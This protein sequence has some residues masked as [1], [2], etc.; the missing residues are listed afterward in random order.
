MVS[1]QRLALIVALTTTMGLYAQ[2]DPQA[3]PAAESA[4]LPIEQE[5]S[6]AADSLGY[7]PEDQNL[8][9][10]DPFADI[11]QEDV[12]AYIDEIR[13]VD[14]PQASLFDNM[15]YPYSMSSYRLGSDFTGF[16][17]NAV[18]IKRQGF[19]LPDSYYQ[20]WLYLGY[21]SQF[22]SFE[23]EIMALDARPRAYEHQVSLS[24]LEGALGDYDS[25]YAQGSFAKGS[26]FGLEGSSMQFDYRLFNG[27]WVDFDN[28]GNSVRQYLG[29]RYK[30]LTFAVDYASYQK[31]GGSYELN[32]AY[33]HLGNFRIKNRYSQLVAQISHPWLTLSLANFQER[34]SSASFSQSWKTESWHVAAEKELILPLSRLDLRY[35]YRDLTRNYSPPSQGFENE[36]RQQSSLDFQH[37]SFAD[38]SLQAQAFDWDKYKTWLELSKAFGP[39][40][41]G[42]YSRMNHGQHDATLEVT[43]PLDATLIPAVD[44]FCAQENALVTGLNY[45]GLKLKLALGRGEEHQ[46]S[47]QELKPELWVLHL[48]GAFD[49]TFGAWRFKINSGWN[50]HEY[51]PYLVAAPEFTFFSEQRVLL[52]LKH[53]NNLQAGFALQGHS[54]YYLPNAVNPY[55]I[56]ASTMLDAWV[57]VRISKLFDF[58][59]TVKNLLSTSIYGLYPIPQSLHANLRWF[60]IN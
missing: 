24:R 23:Q 59:V 45:R 53:D 20:S 28:S 12:I 47:A 44:I 21:L 1:L 33:W 40:S 41:L 25:R 42:V 16:Q 48:S 57:G 32:P 10:V 19:T 30:D 51:D 2:S 50:Y 27:Y 13:E 46:Q 6:P 9:E 60:F 17:P 38:L 52:D 14:F 39:F 26:I 49:K 18:A 4:P 56:E 15:Q 35:E 54:E 7:L 22:Y 3:D 5:P 11:H 31:E 37:S 29:Y 36:Y 34:I 58:T 55:L 43:S 8:K